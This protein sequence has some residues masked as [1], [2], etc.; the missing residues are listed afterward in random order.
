MFSISKIVIVYFRNVIQLTQKLNI[1]GAGEES[2]RAPSAWS[3]SHLSDPVRH[4]RTGRRRRD[5]LERCIAPGCRGKWA[6]QDSSGR[7]A[8]QP[9]DSLPSTGFAFGGFGI[10]HRTGGKGVSQPW[11][12][13]SR[14]R[15]PPPRPRGGSP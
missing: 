11:R 4:R 6:E 14:H 9:A 3:L 8:K 2:T 10:R 7:S 15:R 1:P 5:G 12:R 13:G